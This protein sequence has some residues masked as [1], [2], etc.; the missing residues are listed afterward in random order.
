[1]GV[2]CW[3]NVLYFTTKGL[4]CNTMLFTETKLKGYYILDLESA[5]NDPRPQNSLLPLN[6]RALDGSKPSSSSYLLSAT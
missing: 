1:M 6:T 5:Q 2:A 3:I 4:V